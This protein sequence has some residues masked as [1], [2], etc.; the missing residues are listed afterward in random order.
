MRGDLM[1]KEYDKIKS[2]LVGEGVNVIQCAYVLKKSDTIGSWN[3]R[4]LIHTSNSILLYKPMMGGTAKKNVFRHYGTFHRNSVKAVGLS[5]GGG[6]D[7]RITGTGVKAGKS[8]TYTLE[9]KIQSSCKDPNNGRLYLKDEW[10]KRVK[11]WFLSNGPDGGIASLSSDTSSSNQSSSSSGRSQRIVVRCPDGVSP[12]SAVNIR[13]GNRT[14]TVRVREVGVKLFF[15]F[16]FVSSRELSRKKKYKITRSQVPP[17]VTPGKVFA[18][19]VPAASNEDNDD[20]NDE[21]DDVSS[22]HPDLSVRVSKAKKKTF[23]TRKANTLQRK[24]SRFRF[25]FD[26]SGTMRFFRDN[27]MREDS[28]AAPPLSKKSTEGEYPK[29]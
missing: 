4:L 19:M 25:K 22:K 16:P 12:G 27:G 17:G 1:Q 28:I 26:N 29:L 18:V 15:F 2:K 3:C 14:L 8:G 21:D 9:F 11:D 7:L 13:V 10:A 6:V 24:H 23:A 5:S 20:E